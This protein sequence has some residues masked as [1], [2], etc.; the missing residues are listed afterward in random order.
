MTALHQTIELMGARQNSSKT[1]LTLFQHWKFA[2]D[3][4]IA[5][6]VLWLVAVLE[7]SVTS[8]YVHQQM[9]FA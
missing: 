4:E 3:N 1:L 5:Q 9:E 6:K 7:L 2:C 8:H